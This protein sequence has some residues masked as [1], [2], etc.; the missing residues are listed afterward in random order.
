[1]CTWQ[2]RVPDAFA[3]GGFTGVAGEDADGGIIRWERI[4][5]AKHL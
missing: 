2:H 4:A 3:P 1:V 5:N